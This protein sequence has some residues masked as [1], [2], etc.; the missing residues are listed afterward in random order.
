MNRYVYCLNNPLKYTDPMGN[1]PKT[2]QEIIEEI[3][4]K[5]DNMDQ[6]TLAEMQELIN[7]EKYFEAL[8]LALRVLGYV[9]VIL[10]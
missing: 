6:K 9:I 2:P 1:K 5:M 8:E 4:L 10:P 3:F 7:A